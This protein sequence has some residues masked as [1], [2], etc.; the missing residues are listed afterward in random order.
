MEP[1][2]ALGGWPFGLPFWPIEAVFGPVLAWNLLLLAT[3][4]AG[5]LLAY[6][7]LR[8][9]DLGFVPA[10]VGGLAF[11]IAPYRLAQSADH[12]LGWIAIFL[13]L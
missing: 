5:G 12:L 11:A 9:L 2:A 4:V 6:A 10:L 7:W 13:P 1:Q 3:V 8:A